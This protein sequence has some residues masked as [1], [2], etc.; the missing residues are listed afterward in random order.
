[1]IP[2]TMIVNGVFAG[3]SPIFEIVNWLLVAENW[4]LVPS[5]AVNKG[6]VKVGAGLLSIN[7]YV[8]GK[9]KIIC[10]L[11][12]SLFCVWNVNVYEQSTYPKPFF[13]TAIIAS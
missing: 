11:F 9:V 7:E 2:V 5:E 3:Y 10:E 12:G 1:M 8:E 13:G 4:I 6:A